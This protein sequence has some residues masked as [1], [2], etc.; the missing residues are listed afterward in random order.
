MKKSFMEN[1]LILSRNGN[2]SEAIQNVKF[3]D[4][5]DN[6]LFLLH[7]IMRSVHVAFALHAL[8]M[9]GFFDDCIP[10]IRESIELKSSASFKEIWPHTIKVVSQTPP[11]LAIRWAALFHD[12]GKAKAFSIKNGKVTFH[13]HEH[14]SAKIFSDFAL[15]SKIFNK[16][17]R[18]KIYFLIRNLGW[19]ESYEAEWTDSAV[20]RFAKEM[21]DHLYDILKLSSADITTANPSKR[22]KILRQIK[23][24]T[25]RIESIRIEDAKLPPLPKG[26]GNAIS[27]K[28]GIPLGPEIG[29][30]RLWLESE[31]NLGKLEPNK[32]FDY[33]IDYIKQYK[34]SQIETTNI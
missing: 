11:E 28:L 1:I 3:N 18:E 30:L 7:D 25:E 20:R 22:D 31:I 23:A 29:N 8:N 34:T 10:S 14:M 16:L 9:S 32:D 33:Y 24:L 21:G 5:A 15:K 6:D 12:L 13:H 26:L 27:D 17:L 2:V 4:I 19:A